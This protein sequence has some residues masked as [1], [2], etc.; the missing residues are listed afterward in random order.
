MAEVINSKDG[1]PIS[2]ENPFPV[3]V[4]SGGG[5]TGAS[6]YDIAV[7]N[8]FVG[9]E[10]EWLASLKGDPG[11]PGDQGDPF[12]YADFTTEQL[13]DLEGP[14]GDPGDDGFGTQ[15]EY[16]AIIARLDALEGV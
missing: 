13:V 11:S 3:T 9:T 7:D 12:V 14:K 6:A 2:E 8:G 4:V 10:S 1:K 16:D 15:A 5:G